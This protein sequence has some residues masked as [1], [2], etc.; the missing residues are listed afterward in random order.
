M[1]R[2]HGRRV[3][4]D[5]NEDSFKANPE[6]AF[7]VADGMGGHAAGEIASRIAVDT[8][9]EFIELT[10]RDKDITWPFEFDENITMEGNRLKTAIRLAN[11]KVIGAIQ[12]R[13]DLRGMGTTIVSLWVNGKRAYVG[14]VGDS[15]AYLVRESALSQLTSD[16]SWVNEQQRK[17]T[18]SREQARTHPFRNVVTRALG[19]KEKVEVDLLELEAKRGDLFLLCS[20]GLSSLVDDKAI[21]EIL[22]AK[23]ADLEEA[24]NSLIQKANSQGGDDNSTVILVEIVE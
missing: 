21:L 9:N 4:T 13:E 23:R 5:S 7:V 8:V 2:L 24:C 18:L 3:E 17:G 19:G 22:M 15:R 10:S 16:H 12:K 6:D 11:R 20:D 1:E 14:H